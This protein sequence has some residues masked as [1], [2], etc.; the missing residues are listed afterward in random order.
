MAQS[1]AGA[2]HRRIR[3][4]AIV[5]MFCAKQLLKYGTMRSASDPIV[6]WAN[7]IALATPNYVRATK[8]AKS[9]RVG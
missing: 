1:L 3:R 7:P 9:T 6:H 4:R 8:M 5:R 2:G